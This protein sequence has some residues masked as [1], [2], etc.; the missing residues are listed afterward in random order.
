[1]S[2]E[3]AGYFFEDP[4]RGDEI[5][6]RASAAKRRLIERAGERFWER[7]LADPDGRKEIWRILTDL[8]T[9]ATTFPVSPSGIPDGAAIWF[10]RG[11]ESYGQDFW[12]F[13]L[14]ADRK[15]TLAMMDEHD[16]KMQPTPIEDPRADMSDPNK[17]DGPYE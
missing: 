9:F 8:G 12:K 11:R 13:L 17:T 10:W 14:R 2:D 16:P 3:P 7:C 15:G 6:R 4:E 1:M 5:Q